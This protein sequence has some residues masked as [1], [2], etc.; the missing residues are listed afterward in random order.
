M[1]LLRIGRMNSIDRAFWGDAGASWVWAYLGDK[2]EVLA[3][4]GYEDIYTKEI[5]L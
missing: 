4:A 2:G 5:P 3:A 1:S